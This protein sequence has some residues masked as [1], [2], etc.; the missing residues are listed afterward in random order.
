[1]NAFSNHIQLYR[2]FKALNTCA[3]YRFNHPGE[4]L[5]DYN[6]TEINFQIC[7]LVYY[8]CLF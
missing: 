6:Q 2:T 3:V 1:M 5:Q 4:F 8:L 7:N